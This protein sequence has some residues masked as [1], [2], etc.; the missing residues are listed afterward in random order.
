MTEKPKRMAASLTALHWTAR[1]LVTAWAAFWIVGGSIAK[2]QDEAV[3]VSSVIETMS[4]PG[5]MFAAVALVCW[6]WELIGSL[7]LV[8][9]VV[10]VVYVLGWPDDVIGWGIFVIAPAL[11]AL[12]FFT[13]WVLAR[14]V[15]RVGTQTEEKKP[16]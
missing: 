7:A 9:H 5:L 8:A 1:I 6:K 15:R 13:H 3:Q 14:K 10:T 4:L 2:L 11:T 12:L 16:G